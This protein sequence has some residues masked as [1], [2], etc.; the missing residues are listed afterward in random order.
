[1]MTSNILASVWLLLLFKSAF[2]ADMETRHNLTFMLVTSFGGLGRYNSSGT[3][4][5]AEIALKE[6][7]SHTDILS[8]YN[9]VYDEIRDS[10]VCQ[11]ILIMTIIIF[12]SSIYTSIK[13]TS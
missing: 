1:M 4:P 2:T 7:N 3:L 6:I 13:L 10:R 11:L 9:L 12:C 8:G 5:A